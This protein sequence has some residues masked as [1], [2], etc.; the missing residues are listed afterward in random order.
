MKIEE[1][2]GSLPPTR[3][4]KIIALEASEKKRRPKSHLRKTLIMM[5]KMQWQCW[6]R[7]LKGPRRRIQEVPN[8][9]SA[10]ALGICGNLK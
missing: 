1:L 7:T 3:K 8:V 5:K 9:L 4:A 6:P 2:V 10:Q